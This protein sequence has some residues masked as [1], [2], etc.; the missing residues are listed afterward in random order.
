[1]LQANELTRAEVST[2]PDER[3][4]TRGEAA[5]FL[6][7]QGYRMS[8]ST[9]TKLCSP[10][11]NTGPESIGQWGRDAMYLPSVLLAWARSRMKTRT[12][13]GRGA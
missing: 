5:A 13:A 1:M 2:A 4:L 7:S 3:P 11:I 12:S 8:Y 6:T 9:L 10:A